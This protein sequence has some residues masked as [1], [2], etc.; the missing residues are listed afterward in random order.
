MECLGARNV[1]VK[2]AS[3]S[4]W[5]NYATTYNQR[6]QYQP[7]VIVLPTT[8]QHVSDAVTCASIFNVKVQPK[9]GGHSYA[10]YSTGGTNGIMMIDLQGLQGATVNSGTGIATVGA[11][12]RLGNM[13]TA[14]F[15]QGG[16]ALPHG[17]CPGVGIGGHFLHGGFGYSSRAFGL[18]LDKIVGLDVVLAN[19]TAVYATATANTDVF[20]AMRGAGSSFGIATAFYLQ[21]VAAPSTIINFS[22]SFGNLYSDVSKAVDLFMQVQTVANNAAVTDRNLGMG[23]YFDAYGFSLSG[24]YFGS[25][26][27]YDSKIAPALLNS[28]PAPQTS[29]VQT[30]GWIQSLTKL[31]GASTLTTPAGYKEQD[32]FFAKSVTIPQSSP[33]TRS[34]L[35]SYFTWIK[36]NAASG[37]PASWF[38]IGNIY[39]GVDSQINTKDTSFAA[40]SD[41]DSLWVFQHYGSDAVGSPFTSQQVGWM[42]GLQNALT[43]VQSGTKAYL[44]YVDPTYSREQAWDL[45]YG[46]ALTTK[47]R[48]MKRALDPKNVF[49][50]PQSITPA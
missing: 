41:R 5:S 13:A 34:A 21:T 26:A 44:N 12:M 4:D 48:Q 27:T 11:G 42:A 20:Y 3:A 2:Y 37:S 49:A 43:S 50:N 40:Y 47:L 24:T 19:G 1:P 15:N 10:S 18:A 39:G 22:Y 33:L 29:D 9:S 45:Y 17:T 31:G 36:N 16:R 14:L 38:T 32:N 46:G 6:L 23:I 25:R 35:T 7:S 8:K 30:L 28:L